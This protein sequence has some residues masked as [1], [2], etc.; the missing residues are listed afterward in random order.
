M[1]NPATP[2]PLPAL[3]FFTE[4]LPRT[5]GRPVDRKCVPQNLQVTRAQGEQDVLPAV[6]TNP[7]QAPGSALVVVHGLPEHTQAPG[8][9]TAWAGVARV[10]AWRG[11]AARAGG[12]GRWL[13]AS[14]KGRKAGRRATSCTGSRG[15]GKLGQKRRIPIGSAFGFRAKEERSSAARLTGPGGWPRAGLRDR[16]RRHTGTLIC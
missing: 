16:R 12:R 3:R 14:G 4:C 8:K 7:S 2:L 1:L 6:R 5:S 15:A 11:Q 9:G 10:R 13:R